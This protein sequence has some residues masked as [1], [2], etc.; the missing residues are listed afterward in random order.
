MINPMQTNYSGGRRVARPN[1][2]QT[3]AACGEALGG[4]YANCGDCFAA[5]EQIWEADWAALLAQVGIAPGTE[6]ELALAQRVIDSFGRHPWT[7]MDMAMRRLTCEECGGELGEGFP[8][9]FECSA[10]FGASIQAEFGA[11][12]NEHALHIGRWILRFPHRSSENIVIAWKMSVPRL[13]TGWLPTTA[14]AQRAMDQIK[15]GEVEAVRAAMK[16]VDEAI[17]RAAQA[18]RFKRD[19]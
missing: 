19:S 7:V 3:C 15:V 2:V 18:D 16:Q 8:D 12:P 6:E 13:L 9:C 14:E 10:A 4:G 1:T 11:T 5:V 17:N